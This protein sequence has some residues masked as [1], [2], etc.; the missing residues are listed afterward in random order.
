MT[1]KEE[2]AASYR[3]HPEFQL[4]VSALSVDAKSVEE[5]GVGYALLRDHG[6]S[7]TKTRRAAIESRCFEVLA[8][9]FAALEK[10]VQDVF[11]LTFL[12]ELRAHAERLMSEE[13]AYTESTLRSRPTRPVGPAAERGALALWQRRHFFGSL[14]PRAVEEIRALAR[15]DIERFRVRAGRGELRR[16]DLSVNDGPTVATI[17]TILNREFAANGVLSAVSAYMSADMRVTGAA[18]ELSAPQA[19]WWTNAHPGLQRAPRT[20][21]AH[22]DESLIF[23][24]AIVYLT[25]VATENGP[26]HCYP[27]VYERLDL[28]PLQELI[29]RAL[30]N[31]GNDRTSV[32]SEYY[33]KRYHQSMAA[34]GFRRHFMRLPAQLRFNSHLGWDIYPDSEAERSIV[35][36]EVTML[37]S[38]GTYI[39]FDGARLLHRGGMVEQ[40]E[41]LALQVVFASVPRRRWMNRLLARRIGRL[42]KTAP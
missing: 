42:E 30:A 41:R 28:N 36:T 31:V 18:L 10:Q 5:F 23:P 27:G 2:L 3:V 16:E 24:K 1:L 17:T 35:A 39:V 6:S 25:D 9:I 33:Q 37:G 40:G 13:L 34:P 26:T 14:A 12:R 4:D 32:L 38:R 19:T 7:L 8:M 20:M 29:G 11:E 15:E 21:Y 22:L